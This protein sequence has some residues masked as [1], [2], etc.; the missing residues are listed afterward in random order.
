MN[1]VVLCD[2]LWVHVATN[3][4]GAMLDHISGCTV[5]GSAASLYSCWVRG[6]EMKMQQPEYN[7]G[8]DTI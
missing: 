5:F 6:S 8:K 4:N 2:K 7:V 3:R 1:A